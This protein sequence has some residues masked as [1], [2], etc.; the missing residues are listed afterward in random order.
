MTKQEFVDWAKKDGWE[1]DRFGHFHKGEYR[2][3]VQDRSVR[4]E[5][6]YRTSAS[7]YNKSEKRYVRIRSGFYSKLSVSPDG[8]LLGLER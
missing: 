4:W 5:K 7:Q 2:L 6:M 1:Q 8:T 3:K